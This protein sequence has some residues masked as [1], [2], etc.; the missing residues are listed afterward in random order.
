MK[1]F[2]FYSSYAQ[3]LFFR[4]YTNKKYFV[5]THLTIC[6]ALCFIFAKIQVRTPWNFLAQD[7]KNMDAIYEKR[8]L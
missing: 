6:T 2:N 3:I 7:K 5:Y 1:I 4:K 8:I